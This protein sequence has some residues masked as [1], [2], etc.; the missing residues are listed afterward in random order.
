MKKFDS[1]KSR[2]FFRI[3]I[4]VPLVIILLL[5]A[6]QIA[7]VTWFNSQVYSVKGADSSS[8]SW[9][10]MEPRDDS[11]SFWLKRDFS[12]K[13]KVIDLKA[14]TIDGVFHNTS[15]DTVNSWTIRIEIK[16]DCFINNAWCGTMEIHQFA[17]GGK[18]NVQTLDLRK[19]DLEEITLE[20]L[21]DGDLLIPLHKG[22][23]IIYY[24]SE[25]DDE[26]PIAGGSEL[27][28]GV[29]FYYFD[30]LDFYDYTLDF[31][32]HRTITQGPV[33]YVG[34]VLGVLWIIGIAVYI[35]SRQIYK[36]AQKQLE[37]KKSALS[38][39]SEIYQSIYII[40]LQK[41]SLT[42]VTE[43]LSGD[44][45]RPE[46]LSASEQI[47]H[48]FESDAA[49]IFK[50]TMISFSDLSTL[51]A[52]MKDRQSL[53]AEFIS[54]S[55]GWCCIRFFAM[56]RI[57]GRELDR[58]LFTIQIIDDEKREMDAMT[59]KITFVEREMRANAA[60][61]NSISGEMLAPVEAILAVEKDLR[62]ENNNEAQQRSLKTLRHETRTLESV[63]R[64]IQEYSMLESGQITPQKK[65]FVLEGLLSDVQDFAAE[66]LDGTGTEFRT[67][68][69]P[70]LPLQIAG[71]ERILRRVLCN[72]ISAAH[73]HTKEGS[74]CF[75]VFAGRKE[76]QAHL[77]FSVRDTGDGLGDE[78]HREIGLILAEGLLLELRSGLEIINTPGTGTEAYFELETDAVFRSTEKER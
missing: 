40:D 65:L 49:D 4:I 33:Y 46:N 42:V 53:A 35:A 73:E 14:Q 50:E 63:L 11:T 32:Y 7:Y 69:G 22:D 47:R 52:R 61:L 3:L 48:L 23:Y 12:W 28:M 38:I 39:M 59:D 77:V 2:L 34:L 37:L 26:I 76:E 8:E 70:N 19:Y 27:T 10:D 36:D 45:E 62:K 54:K 55:Q 64:D 72:L 21:Y 13:G 68:Q 66:L 16:D 31:S 24:P 58:V 57:E 74:I 41:D 20:H 44:L 51:S 6:F 43:T 9:L 71:D 56:D 5:L 15:A 75:S 30:S 29:I 18:E 25:I 1:R 17:E 67:D 60:F 78:K